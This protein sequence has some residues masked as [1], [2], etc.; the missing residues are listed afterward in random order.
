[1][2]VQ[3]TKRGGKRPNAGRPSL[4]DNVKKQ[5]V[6]IRV[7]VDLLPA[8]EELKNNSLISV[9]EN[10]M[11]KTELER[12]KQRNQELVMKYDAEHLRVVSL[13]SK[14]EMAKR[15][16]TQLRYEIKELEGKLN[17][18]KHRQCQRLTAN[19]LQCDRKAM[20]ECKLNGFVIYLCEQHYKLQKFD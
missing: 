2:D 9:T 7:D 20:N 4:P 6:V 14:L 3:K 8:I 11:V 17:K 1:M 16:P 18:Q 5:T 19:G 12:F 15:E 13:T 10:Q